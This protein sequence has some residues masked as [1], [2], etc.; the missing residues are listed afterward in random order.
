MAETKK[1]DPERKF[2]PEDYVIYHD[3]IDVTHFL[4]PSLCRNCDD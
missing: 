2:R 4:P 1:K 3:T